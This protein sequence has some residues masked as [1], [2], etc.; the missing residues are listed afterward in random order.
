MA[1]PPSSTS[2]TD[3]PGTVPTAA[4]LDPAHAPRRVSLWPLPAPPSL[5]GPAAWLVPAVRLS[6]LVGDILNQSTC[7]G[8]P[9]WASNGW[10]SQ[11]PVDSR[12]F[13]I[14]G[15]A[16]DTALVAEQPLLAGETPPHR[17]ASGKETEGEEGLAIKQDN[18][19][20]EGEGPAHQEERQGEAASESTKPKRP[21]CGPGQRRWASPAYDVST[22]DV[23]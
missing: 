8:A 14:R 19:A 13:C 12:V 20:L 1:L 2:S 17:K 16:E 15:S 22:G 5:Q 10:L 23:H 11:G 9:L 3:G 18:E 7:S 4:P 21:Q 6:E